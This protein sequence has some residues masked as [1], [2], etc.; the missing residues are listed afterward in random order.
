MATDCRD[1]FA[2][3]A[4]QVLDRA[5]FAS[6]RCD[7]STSLAR[8]DFPGPHLLVHPDVLTASAPEQ[9]AV[10][11]HEVAHVRLRHGRH[12]TGELGVF[13]LVLAFVSV[14]V[15]GWVSLLWGA[16]VALVG[17]FVIFPFVSA[18][19]D[20]RRECRA[21]VYAAGLLTELG[22]DGP[23]VMAQTLRRFAATRVLLPLAPDARMYPATSLIADARWARAVIVF[24]IAQALSGHPS[25]DRRLRHVSRVAT[26]H[27]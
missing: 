13:A 26:P 25:L 7:A 8:V 12:L 27:P 10:V 23:C 20:R 21:D 1:N 2:P 15:T 9:A 5:G 16:A 17:V 3:A 4:R 11:A 24:R 6:V 14:A 22:W 18:A 19:A